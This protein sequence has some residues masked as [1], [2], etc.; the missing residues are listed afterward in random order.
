VADDSRGGDI[1]VG[2]FVGPEFMPRVGGGAVEDLWCRTGWLAFADEQPIR[3][4]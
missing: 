1:G 3:L 2:D 4:P